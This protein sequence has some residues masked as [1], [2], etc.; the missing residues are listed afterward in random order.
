M[1]Q[2]TVSRQ[3]MRRSVTL[4]LGRDE[5]PG[6]DPATSTLKSLHEEIGRRDLS[7]KL[8]FEFVGLVA[9]TKA[10]PCD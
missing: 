8:G 4:T 3:I 6:L 5:R 9:G 1:Q 7:Q 2:E 10:V